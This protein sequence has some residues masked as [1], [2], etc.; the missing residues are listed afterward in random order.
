MNFCIDVGYYG[1]RE[2]LCG[3]RFAERGVLRRRW[4]GA[5]HFMD[6]A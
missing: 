6:E 1:V 5:L 3:W 2:G 4:G